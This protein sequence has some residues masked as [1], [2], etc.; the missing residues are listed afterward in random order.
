MVEIGY[1]RYSPTS[2]IPRFKAV[3]SRTN[4]ANQ[5]FQLAH[6]RP[7]R[8]FLTP[9]CEQA[10]GSVLRRTAVAGVAWDVAL[11]LSRGG[12]GVM[13]A[14]GWEGEGLYPVNTLRNVALAQAA[15]R[16]VFL[17]DAD[18]LPSP[19]LRAALDGMTTTW[20]PKV[21]TLKRRSWF[22]RGGWRG[23]EVQLCVHCSL[24]RWRWWCQLWRRRRLC[25][26]QPA[27]RW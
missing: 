21:R 6:V 3:K 18:F 9:P 17:V 26:S 23:G 27:W 10:L 5:C 2:F 1:G 24:P 7:L 14:E 15:T 20:D 11:V 16:L 22:C 13:G 12:H 8:P 19:G 4:A 25:S